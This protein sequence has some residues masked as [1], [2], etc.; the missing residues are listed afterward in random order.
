[1][2]ENHSFDNYFGTYPGADGP[3]EGR[4]H[5]EGDSATATAGLRRTASGSATRR[6]LDLA[7][8][9]PTSPR[10][11]IDGGKMDGFVERLH[12]ARHQRRRS[13]WGTTTTATCPYYWNLADNYVLFDRFFTSAPRRQ[14]LEPH[15]LG[16]GH[17]R[18][19]GSGDVIPAEGFARDVPTIFDRLEAKGI[20]WKFYVQNYDPRITCRS[21]PDARRPTSS[22]P[23]GCRC[24]TYRA[25][26]RRPEALRAHRRH[27]PVL[28]ATRRTGRC[29]PSRTSS[30]P[31][32]ASIRP[33]GIQAGE[34]FV[35][36]HRSPR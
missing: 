1:M 7:H 18:Q 10:S 9:R 2:Q 20:S 15:V 14:R 6:P 23:S 4:V 16:H 13:R 35:R 29:R 5:A 31:A 36:T 12:A 17:A 28:R 11:S 26:R 30:R 8:T 33:G 34:A 21:T 19:P 3:A 25:V 24:S 27:E 32:R 22:Q